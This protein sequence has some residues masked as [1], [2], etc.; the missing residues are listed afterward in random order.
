MSQ[1]FNY[2]RI[3]ARCIS[4]LARAGQPCVVRVLGAKTGNAWDPTI[5]SPTLIDVTAMTYRPRLQPREGS[6]ID[7]IYLR[8]LVMPQDG[9]D[10]GQADRLAIGVE[11]ADVDAS[12]VWLE[13]SDVQK[14]APGGPV[15]FWEL[16]LRS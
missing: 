6:L 11:A 9:L 8:A 12:T 2:T 16:E 15:L 10:I 5:G 4:A 13:V 14:F 3:Q 7:N 1:A